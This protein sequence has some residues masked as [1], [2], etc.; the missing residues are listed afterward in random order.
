[1][2]KIPPAD[3]LALEC[4]RCLH[5][6]AP[7]RRCLHD[8]VGSLLAVAGLRLQLL[9]MD[10]PDAG[11][12]ATEVSEAIDEAME[13][14][15][16]LSRAWS[17][18]PSAA[19]GLKN[20]L[21]DLAESFPGVTVRYTTA[22]PLPSVA[23]DAIYRAIANSSQRRRG[24]RGSRASRFPFPAPGR[25][26]AGRTT[27]AFAR[28]RQG[29]GRRRPAG[30]SCRLGLRNKNAT[31]KNKTGYNCCHPICRSTSYWS[32]TTRSCGMASKP[33]WS[34]IPNFAWSEKPRS[35]ADALQFVKLHHPE[36]V[37]MDIGLPGLNGVETTAEILRHHPEC[38][39]V[40]LSM[41]DDENSVVGAVRSGARGFILKKVSDN[42]LIEALRVV[43]RGGAY[44]S[45]QVSDRLLSR[46]QKGDLESKQPHVRARRPLAARSAGAAHGRGRQ[47]QQG[48]R[49]SA[50]L[51]RANRPQ[52]PQDHDEKTGH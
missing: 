21:L 6:T 17:H 30:P 28:R 35:G 11:E 15:R 42:D 46:I 40:I 19:R 5:R 49:Q 24:P 3:E 44:L 31:R 2:A 50:G 32:M 23:A 47:N 37:L 29:T 14:V 10:F 26:G 27:T 20:A 12:R 8:D 51:A 52:L 41:Y 1:M 34:V 18:R 48:N 36:L 4:V 45:P 33:F 16:K 39:V 13:H 7:R 38:K 43:A 25:C 9:C 22:L